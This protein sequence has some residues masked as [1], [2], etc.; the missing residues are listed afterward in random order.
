VRY[1]TWVRAKLDVT[2]INVA[3]VNINGSTASH[4][5]HLEDVNDDGIADLVAHLNHSGFG[6]AT[7]T[8]G[9]NMCRRSP[10]V[11]L[12]VRC[13]RSG[14]VPFRVLFRLLRS[15]RRS[16]FLPKGHS[17]PNTIFSNST[18]ATLHRRVRVP[19]SRPDNAGN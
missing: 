17:Q 13:S 2:A 18:D 12:A 16:L 10:S 11:V 3:T 19:R 15:L 5:G 8:P 14:N 4:N 7:E 9:S 6:I 1:L